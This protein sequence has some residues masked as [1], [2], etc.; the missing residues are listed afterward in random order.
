MTRRHRH[1]RSLR[2]GGGRSPRSAVGRERLA[3]IVEAAA[4]RLTRLT[5]AGRPESAIPAFD[6][7]IADLP[8]IARVDRCL[9]A[10][11]VGGAL[12]AT[13]DK[14]RDGTILITVFARPL[15]LWSGSG[16]SLARL[17]RQSLAEQLALAVDQQPGQLDPEA[18]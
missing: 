18:G 11:V 2:I 12:L 7:A 17:V 3:P 4:V 6:V 1:G 5:A 13:H 8:P 14:T 9:P 15:L 10:D 16:S